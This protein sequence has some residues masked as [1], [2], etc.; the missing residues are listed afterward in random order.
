MRKARYS[1]EIGIITNQQ[2]DLPEV[3]F[4]YASNL[5]D[6]QA[7]NNYDW[8]SCFFHDY[9]IKHGISMKWRIIEKACF[10]KQKLHDID[11]FKQSLK[12]K[13]DKWL[14]KKEGMKR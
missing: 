1:L 8:L 9:C 3:W 7:L 12:D 5:L 6:Y 2:I 10:H 11:E 13:G 4:V 14:A